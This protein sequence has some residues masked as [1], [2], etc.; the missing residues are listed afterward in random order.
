MFFNILFFETFENIIFFNLIIIIII[1]II[2]FNDILS[3]KLL[4]KYIFYLLLKVL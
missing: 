4:L 2:I 1:I 3:F